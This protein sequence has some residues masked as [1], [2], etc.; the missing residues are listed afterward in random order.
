MNILPGHFYDFKR[1]RNV[2]RAGQ[3]QYLVGG[4]EIGLEVTIERA[5]TRVKAGHDVYTPYEA[6]AYKLAARIDPRMPKSEIHRANLHA[7]TR[8]G[9][10]DVFFQHYHPGDDRAYGH[11]FFGNRGQGL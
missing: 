2:A 5:F 7:P 11:I 6:D 1:D 10:D 3:P 8:S 9:R 4:I